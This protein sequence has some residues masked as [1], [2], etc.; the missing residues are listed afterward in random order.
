MPTIELT[1]EQQAIVEAP[2]GHYL[3]RA[4][5]GSGKT[6]T[7]AF[8]IRHLLTTGIDPRRV[9]VLMFNKSAQLDFQRKL[10]EVLQGDMAI[11][12]V[13]TFHAMG[14]RLYK[15]FI[16]LNALPAYHGN[17]LSEREIQFHLTQLI[18]RCLSPEQQTEFKRYKKEYLDVA[19]NFIEQCKGQLD[20]AR[21]FF[22]SSELDA[23]F[24]FLPSLF[25]AFEDWRKT[26]KRIGYADML[27]DPVLA[28]RHNNELRRLVSDKIDA[29]LVDEYQDTNDIQ[30]ELL[31]IIAGSRAKIT[32]VGD[33]D[34][35]I[36]EFRGAKPQYMLSGFAQERP[37]STTLN[38]STSFRYGHQVALLANQLIANSNYHDGTLCIPKEQNPK[39]QVRLI[40]SDAELRELCQSIEATPTEEYRASAVL[41]R[42]WSQTAG[43]EL[44]LLRR[45]I[46]YRLEGH[47]GIFGS[48]EMFALRCVLEL[49]AGFFSQMN[50]QEREQRF[51]QLARFPHVGINERT[52]HS[53]M[54][55]L[56]HHESRWG[57]Q[58]LELIPSDLS[59]YQ[60][61]KLER[62]ARALSAAERD[63]RSSHLVID[64]YAKET[65]LFDEL[66]SM[67]LSREASEEQARVLRSLIGFVSSAKSRAAQVLEELAQLEARKQ[68]S[69]SNSILLTTIHRAKGLEWQHVF[70]PGL[71]ES[72][73]F[74][75]S[76]KKTGKQS[77]IASE[78]RLLYVA[79]TR[80][81]QTLTMLCP[82]KDSGDI[83]RF[84]YEMQHEQ[85]LHLA[86]SIEQALPECTLSNPS[87]LLRNYAERFQCS[88]KLSPQ[89]TSN[90]GAQC[91]AQA[92][93]RDVVTHRLLGKGKVVEEEGET[94]TVEFE[95][96]ERRVFSKQ[97]A[98]KVFIDA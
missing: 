90:V 84:I 18:G 21:S 77:P 28:I 85:S 65:H 60:K 51:M 59:R 46:D 33:P 78:R 43:I 35:T 61:L 88:L 38:L 93:T 34:Q 95:D 23:K 17:I 41:V 39:T 37:D 6:T 25:D 82:R 97:Y 98:Q 58:L 79:M 64:T 52:V 67:G 76:S 40:S 50:E 15:R 5:A 54:Q 57:H 42:Y 13:R 8:R 66:K 16:A 89:D 2:L 55:Q 68:S 10:A 56:S 20:D 81:K 53:I 26:N 47:Q 73:Y 9:V 92:W 87:E 94:F 48:E 69:S 96:R 36:Y 75:Q 3:I 27:Y 32:I 29:V 31:T 4:V 12:E 44:S 91:T 14:F 22:N 80:A 49:S 72:T 24:S 45:N 83:L 63:Q 30:H 62:L 11:P 86:K 70:L 7:L 71:S 19:S 1:Q 74:T